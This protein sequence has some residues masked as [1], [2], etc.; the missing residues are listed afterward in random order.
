LARQANTT[1][2]GGAAGVLQLIA[3]HQSISG[4]ALVGSSSKWSRLIAYIAHLR[5]V[6]T[7]SSAHGGL[8]V[9][10]AAGLY[11]RFPSVGLSMCG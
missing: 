3:S 8:G 5:E 1:A 6:A 11:Q 10:H 9:D 4:E 7:E 2:L